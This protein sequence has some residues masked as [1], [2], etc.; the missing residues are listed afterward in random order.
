MGCSVSATSSVDT[1][2]RG[3][4]KSGKVGRVR[5]CR[6]WL[7]GGYV[8]ASLGQR[9]HATTHFQAAAAACY[10]SRPPPTFST[11]AMAPT[12]TAVTSTKQGADQRPSSVLAIAKP[13]PARKPTPMPPLQR[14]GAAAGARGVTSST[15]Q[16]TSCGHSRSSSSSSG[17]K[18]PEKM[19][20]GPGLA[21]A[22]DGGRED[23]AL[24]VFKEE[25]AAQ[26]GRGQKWF[27][28]LP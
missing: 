27:S 1:W 3:R 8:H 6:R 24:G 17:R 19:Q 22:P 16:T 20:A 23:Q 26:Q 11:P 14:G 21:G 15:Y 25:A 28:K 2:A 4:R 9:L 12:D 18:R 7:C 5:G 10:P 13:L